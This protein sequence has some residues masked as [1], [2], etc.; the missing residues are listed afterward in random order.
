LLD[1]PLLSSAA[2][3]DHRVDLHYILYFE[4]GHLDSRTRGLV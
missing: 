1:L 3:H 4:S 2:G